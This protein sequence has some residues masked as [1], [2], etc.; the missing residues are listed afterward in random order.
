LVIC[1][2]VSVLGLSGSTITGAAIATDTPAKAAN[3]KANPETNLNPTV[4]KPSNK[5]VAGKRVNV[6]LEL[7]DEPAVSHFTSPNAKFR[8]IAATTEVKTYLNQLESKQQAL[9]KPLANLK[10]R[11]IYRV[12]QVYNG[13]A[14]NIEEK[15]LAT[16]AKLP[17]VKAIQPLPTYY[18]S[19]LN[20]ASL[21]G[22]STVWN[23]SGLN[24]HGEGI[25]I[26]IIDSGIDY[27]H[28]NFGGNGTDIFP[29]TKVISGT[30]FVGDA[31][32]GTNI[33]APDDDPLDCIANGHGTHV[34]GIAAG[35]G[36]D[37]SGNPYTGPYNSTLDP[38]NFRIGPGIAPQADLYALRVFGCSG[39]SQL[40]VPAIEW[41]VANN[42]DV[43]N[44]SLGSG[45]GADT[46]AT[47]VAANNAASAG[48]I[49]VAA[50]GNSGD[51]FYATSSPGSADRAISVASSVDAGSVSSK[52]VIVSP[53]GIAGQYVATEALFGPDLAISGPLT[54]TVG[55]AATNPKACAPFSSS[56]A[57]LVNGNI[58]LV[59]RGGCS[60]KQ[61]VVYAQSAGAS[62]VLVYNDQP[63]DPITM[64]DD[65]TVST[66]ILIPSMMTDLA[67]GNLIKANLGGAVVKVTL[68]AQFR[69]TLT[70]N[71]AQVDTL[72]SFS[73][74]GPRRGDSYLK[75]DLTAP[76]DTVYSTKVGSVNQ[77]LS[78][79]GTSMASP[80]VAGA[81]ALLKQ[82]NPGWSVEEVK[83][84][85]MNTATHDL[86]TSPGSSTKYGVS[87]IGAGRLDL[88]NATGSKVLAFN[89]DNSGRVSLSYGAPE[90]TS[91]T[92]LTRTIRLVNK[93]ISDQNYNVAYTALTDAPGVT[94]TPSSSTVTV[95]A[96]G[97]VTITVQLT[98]NPALMRHSQD[99]A[100]SA[101]QDNQPRFW[102]SEEG[103]YITLT[104][105]VGQVLRVPL[106]AAPR[107]AS[108]MI[109]SAT[110]NFGTQASATTTI[111]LSGTAI[112]TGSNFPT[113]IQSLVTP[114]EWQYSSPS[115]P[116]ITATA[117]SADLQYVGI[118]SDYRLSNSLGNTNI[119]FGLATYANWSTPQALDT[120][121]LI[122]IDSN[123]D[124][125]DDYLLYNTSYAEAKGNSNP[126][127][128]L[129]SY[130]CP[131]NGGSCAGQPE[132]YPFLGG[133]SPASKDLPIYNTNALVLSVPATRLGLTSL[134]SRFS[135]HIESYQRDN[136]TGPVEVTPT[137]S[138]NA[139]NPGLSF[140]TGGSTGPA[141][142][143]LPGTIPV[144]YN[145]A[146]YLGAGSKGVLLFHHHNATVNRVQALPATVSA[147][148]FGASVAPGGFINLGFAP[149]GQIV[150]S[151]LIIS[152]TGNLPLTISSAVISGADASYFSIVSPAFPQT[153]NNGGPALAV[154]LACN[155]AQPGPRIAT[156]SFTTNDPSRPTV[157]YTLTCSGVENFIS[158][159]EG[160][161]WTHPIPQG[162]FVGGIA[163]PTTTVCYL[164]GTSGLILVT[165]DNGASYTAQYTGAVND[166]NDV[167]CPNPSVCY[168]IGDNG[169]VIKS[170]DAGSS[171]AIKNNGVPAKYL[172]AITCLDTKTCLAVGEDGLFVST[173]NGGDSWDSQATISSNRDL[174]DIF[175]IPAANTC[176]AVGGNYKAG[177]TDGVI[178]KT[179]N[180]GGN[181][182]E[183]Y[184]PGQDFYWGITCFNQTNCIVVGDG[185]RIVKSSNGG[186][187]WNP[188]L[189]GTS[190]LQKIFCANATV[191]YTVGDGG[192]IYKSTNSGVSWQPQQSNTNNYLGNIA[193]TD[194]QHCIAIGNAAILTTSDGSTWTGRT[195]SATL[196]NLNTVS[197][198]SESS[199]YVAGEFGTI[200]ATN[201]RGNTWAAQSSGTTD[202]IK[203]I[204]CPNI[205]TCYAISSSGTVIS[206]TNSGVN[207]TSGTLPG[208]TYSGISCPSALTCYVVGSNGV[209]FKTT[210]GF[211]S[212]ANINN[213]GVDNFLT[214]VSC[215]DPKTCYVVGG[216]GEVL[217][218]TNGVSWTS[219]ATGLGSPNSI[220]CATQR[221]CFAVG[222]NGLVM[223]TTDGTS[224]NA[225][226]V[227]GV[228][229]Q[230][231][232]VSCVS[233]NTCTASGFPGITLK[234]T[235]G[236]LNWKVERPGAGFGLNGIS[237]FGANNICFT[238]GGNGTVLSNL[239]P[240]NPRPS[241]TGATLL[242]MS[243]STTARCVAVGV[244]G[245]IIT[246]NDGGNSWVSRVSGTI[247][248]LNG[249]YCGSRC[250]AVGE[251]G[252]ILSSSDNGATWSSQP[253]G[254][255]QILNGIYCGSR[256]VAVGEYGTILTSGDGGVTWI[257]QSSGTT[258]ILNGVYCGS[259]CVAV[260]EYG[261]ILN[262]SNGGDS[263]LAQS[264]GITRTLNGVYCG[265]R[266]VAVGEYGTIL[267]ASSNGS[268]WASTT[269]RSINNLA[270]VSCDG[271]GN[272][273]SSGANG[274]ILAST[275]G[276]TNWDYQ[277]SSTL[278]RLNNLTC[279]SSSCVSVGDLGTVVKLP[280]LLV[281]TKLVDDGQSGSLSYILNIA[282]SGQ[283]I[284]FDV[285]KGN[286][287]SISGQL[288]PVPAGV[289]ITGSCSA[290]GPGVII[291]GTGA[292]G[293][294][295][296]SGQN[297][298]SGLLIRHFPGPQLKTNGTGNKLTCVKL[299]KV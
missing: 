12:Q 166:I 115:D 222:D 144:N 216:L 139:A 280:S 85:L 134:N 71:N 221:N 13:I 131:L 247:R 42:L 118:G 40:I 38:A 259:R 214:S 180:G 256:C 1:L 127:D 182:N 135:Y 130:L 96:S 54:A 59:E 17:G 45:F 14:L 210:N 253:S 24:F 173:N 162:N 18:P 4:A 64:F 87:R 197:C 30:D 251:Y 159:G 52:F 151:T 78:L 121:F 136:A 60:F 117:Q 171:W 275:N 165:A 193:C 140:G 29:T 213:S 296:L 97:S 158:T 242:S 295:V 183:V 205:N 27:K 32:D 254:T 190:N 175:C 163:C 191:C 278:R 65:E 228:T 143:D 49:V 2:V 268:S 181:W 223:A 198:P 106:Y 201:N 37:L 26:G 154:V 34:A 105:S 148:G 55:F 217:R 286:V 239:I 113:D 141:V 50:S 187:V 142:A 98:A 235:D 227:A 43:I 185:G 231:Q 128:S 232:A 289:K 257:A 241:S 167:T 36:V 255:T 122:Y 261:T 174:E 19:D 194:A 57:A 109:G 102:L 89:G 69:N 101:T 84:S 294:F 276:G 170:D 111:N 66:P 283:E 189:L 58:A 177:K 258:Q 137:F 153:I 92:I 274:A 209:I 184:N 202:E 108:N 99:A 292:L 164:S 119:Y 11:I 249:V 212:F 269:S 284:T 245:T 293:S 48:V 132:P 81:A 107:P 53:G 298:L 244:N 79:S 147:P 72:S 94:V 75:P 124:G 188:S 28:A 129:V 215:V 149:V 77:G 233:D 20:S 237:C 138:Y 120:E 88:V 272:C 211:S 126:S 225:I 35:Q 238:V 240:W 265:S 56:E 125:L 236:G 195:S 146:G 291:D 68:T 62:G 31:Y 263:W 7:A 266:C 204:S 16:V 208:F 8:E 252:T 114:L 9:L 67:T 220:S 3:P 262:S 82:A 23:N 5:T 178:V 33:P 63:G 207:W 226:P 95:P 260:G 116:T 168:A 230:L 271:S 270:S 279:T 161:V 51:T 46:D 47:A 172:R 219:I 104:P 86:L 74:R 156:L 93:G 299:S 273:Y 248:N 150:T 192:E 229:T 123:N 160:W 41:A 22:A 199:C 218:T 250:V 288:P 21:I 61:K 203:G 83:A 155:L 287:F 110:L 15:E 176:Y 70:I 277:P 6:V 39:G 152:E 186:D 290:G 281:V 76:G 100:L 243:C 179:T 80:Q 44:L 282:R 25:K 91:I 246:S 224:W 145:Q 200:I 264:S 103:G 157:Q 133:Y 10:A 234:T 206:T 73:S 90:I 297:S 267:N 169:T 285:S 112:N 196:N